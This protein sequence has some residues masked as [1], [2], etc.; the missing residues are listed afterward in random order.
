MLIRIGAYTKG[1]DIELDEAIEKKTLWK[2]F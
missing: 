1:T 2:S